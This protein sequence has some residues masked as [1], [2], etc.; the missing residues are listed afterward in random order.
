MFLQRSALRKSPLVS[1]YEINEFTGLKWYVKKN[2]LSWWV[3]RWRVISWL[4]FRMSFIN[5]DPGL[6][7]SYMSQSLKSD[8]WLLGPSIDW[9]QVII[10]PIVIHS[11]HF[12][13]SWKN[14]FTL[15]RIFA[16]LYSLCFYTV[17]FWEICFL[18]YYLF[19]NLRYS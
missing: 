12:Y 17:L 3:V 2:M 15:S 10:L 7:P 13:C 11:C 6:T 18:R 5:Q 1:Q 4:A 19:S 8:I 16:F 14:V 9:L